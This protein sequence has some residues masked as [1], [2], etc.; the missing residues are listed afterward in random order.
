MLFA[1]AI[2]EIAVQMAT[3]V[4]AVQAQRP[5][6]RGPWEGF[7]DARCAL[8]HLL[9][10]L[11]LVACSW[12][13]WSHSKATGNQEDTKDV[14]GIGFLVLLLDLWLVIAYFVIAKSVDRIVSPAGA[15]ISFVNERETEALWVL[16]TFIGYA[17]WDALTK[18]RRDSSELQFKFRKLITTILKRYMKRGWVS[19]ICMAF[20]FAVYESLPDKIPSRGESPNAVLLTDGALLS[21]VFLFRALKQASDARSRRR[22]VFWA[23][24]TFVGGVICYCFSLVS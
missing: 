17:I 4:Q 2:G 8:M 19:L 11:A 21:L 16:V 18:L 5:A 20:A 7:W 14:F 3:L 1:L 13:G 10:V 24:I 15:P 23:V 22:G 9:L 12:V 6:G